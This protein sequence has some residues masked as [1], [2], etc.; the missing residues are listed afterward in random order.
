MWFIFGLL[1]GAGLLALVVWLHRWK[2]VVKWYEWLIGVI[3]LGL[4]LFMIQNIAGSVREMETTAA[5]QFL[6]I[7]GLP[8][9]ILLTL[10]WWLPWRRHRKTG[11]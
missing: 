9:I 5:W 1:I 10:A 8:A 11:S 7:I 3:G 4:L 6:W 2:I